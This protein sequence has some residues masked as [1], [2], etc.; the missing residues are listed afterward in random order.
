MKIKIKIFLLLA[1][2]LTSL[3]IVS[4]SSYVGISAVGH[5]IEELAES[6]I[7][8]NRVI[9][10]IEAGI[11]KEE[12]L[13]YELI[14]AAEDV[15][16]EKFQEV[17]V[18]IEKIEKTSE[19]N[20]KECEEIASK[21]INKSS[22][23]EIKK[24]YEEFLKECKELEK[25]QKMFEV[26][27]AKLVHDLESG[28][29]QDVEKEKEE[30][31]NLLLGLDKFVINLTKQIQ[32]LVKKATEKAKADENSV[33]IT[34][35][36]ISILAFIIS[37]TFGIYLANNIKNLINTFQTGL[38]G[39]FTYLNRESNDVKPIE[40]N[41]NDEI[42][43]MSKVV[44]E[45]IIRT[46]DLLEEDRELI[47][48]VKKIVT[49]V[50]S[51]IF[52]QE[53]TKSTSNES[54]N[55]LKSLLN[56]M[57]KVLTANV[58]ED[59]NK[60]QVALDHYQ[61]L[62]FRHRIEGCSGK[63]SVGL[64]KLAEIINTML[65]ENKKSGV[66]L[67]ISAQALLGNITTLNSSSNQAAA[68]LEETAAALEEITSTIV[69]NTEN[70]VKMSN[71]ANELSVSANEGQSLATQTTTSMDEINAQVSAINE[72]ISVIDQIAFQTNILSLNAAVEAATA[73]ESGK[74]FAV[75]AGEVRNLASRSAEAA[76][77]IKLLVENATIKASEGKEIATRMING[78]S[79]LNDNVDKTL[80]IIKDIELAS[81]E[82]QT[83]I[84]QI[85]DA[86]NQLDQQTQANASAA[87]E[88]QEVANNTSTIANRII[89]DANEKEFIGKED[90]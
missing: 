32:D 87:A 10:N 34:I 12:V 39:F 82:Q 76:K 44:N 45:N 81:K 63:T 13:T 75:V 88:A 21:A 47:D 11:L 23:D 3:L 84:V 58:S 73:G 7:P 48:E 65:V 67:N 70:V 59:L 80:A 27:I 26:G 57:L 60:I 4:V 89:E 68:S 83:G 79:G 55:E 42:G 15:F 20:I 41:S 54:L 90:I 17:K 6:H 43:L 30:L 8:L 78:Y 24:R 86:V 37:I 49:K 40:I 85:N 33:T 14:I 35:E 53:I 72:A 36:I 22:D 62:D 71:Y 74:G 50:N 51:G 19:K 25:K 56:E 64:T 31:H 66:S 77:E 38:L 46:K 69:S 9:T 52:K 29:I 2:T 18:R 5:E 61:Q 16:S 1:I 28:N